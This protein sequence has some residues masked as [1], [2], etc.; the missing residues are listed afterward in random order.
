MPKRLGKRSRKAYKSGGFGS[1]ASG[2]SRKYRRSG[3][4]RTGGL[5]R[6]R[7]M[8]SRRGMVR[9][10]ELKYT[11]RNVQSVNAVAGVSDTYDTCYWRGPNGVE[12][13]AIQ[14]GALYR[15]E[16]LNFIQQQTGAYQRIG[17]KLI[18][19]S[20]LIDLLIGVRNTGNQSVAVKWW[21]CLDRQANGQGPNPGDVLTTTNGQAPVNVP[22]NAQLPTVTWV[23]NIA[24][25]QRFRIMKEK[26]FILTPQIVDQIMLRKCKCYIKC[27][28]PI[29]YGGT[30]GAV[31]EIKSNNIFMMISI[32][33]NNA[34]TQ[35]EVMAADGMMRLRYLDV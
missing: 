6:L 11:D 24:N 21:L 3:N 14:T 12:S 33:F 19:K 25:R 5:Y 30:T 17:R 8:Q 4:V 7:G 16:N 9:Q 32:S 20:I 2:R 18:I 28:I 27:N 26:E 35:A 15:V 1:R 22:P 23:P 34:V 29:E 10:A 13:N 31:A